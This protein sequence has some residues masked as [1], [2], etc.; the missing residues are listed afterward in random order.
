LWARW[1]GPSPVY[2][3]VCMLVSIK[4]WAGWQG[5]SPVYGNVC[6]LESMKLWAS[7][8]GASPVYGNV[9]MLE[10]KKLWA[11]WQ[12]P[13]PVYGNVCAYEYEFVCKLTRTINYVWKCVCLWVWS[14][15]QVYKDHHLCTY[16]CVCACKYEVV[17]ATALH[18]VSVYTFTWL[19][20]VPCIDSTYVKA[21][22][23]HSLAYC[24]NSIVVRSRTHRMNAVEHHLTLVGET[25]GTSGQCVSFSLIDAGSVLLPA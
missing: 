17:R 8:Q 24:C 15:E 18:G 1:Q 3:Y 6:M 4:L 7:W 23:R 21:Q 22:C 5:A 16:M 20:H 14:C 19:D 12:G 13:S 10:S 11:S 2:V 25:H 9:C